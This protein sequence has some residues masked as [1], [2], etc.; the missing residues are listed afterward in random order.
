MP[1]MING[2]AL[3]SLL[4]ATVLQALDLTIAT[5][6]LPAIEGP[7]GL[8]FESGAWILTSYL[9]ALALMTP[10]AGALSG[11]IGR[12]NALLAAIAGLTLASAACGAA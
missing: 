3:F 11:A 5:I 2:L 4:T 1:A 9:V 10:V 7:L 6:A 12:R 8:D